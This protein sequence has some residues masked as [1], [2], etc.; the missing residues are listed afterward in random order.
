MN[1][2]E[3]YA[4][5][6]LDSSEYDSKLKEAGTGMEK[7]GGA[8]S[9]GL[10][11]AAA[12]GAAAVG[13]ASA[14]V[15]GLAKEALS[16]Y[17]EYEQ[18]VGGVEKLYG[19]ASGKIQQFADEAYK[20]SGMSANTY[21]E[22]ATSFSASLIK[23]L[24][25][26]VNKAAELTDVA[27]RAMS[28]NINVFGSDMGSVTNAFQGF[29][30]QNYTM[31]DNLKLGYGGTKEEM[32]KLI[33]DANEYAA[34]IGQASDLSIDSFADIVQAI[35]LI[36]EKQ[37]IAGTTGKEAMTTLEGSATATKAA[38]E[39]VVTA[40]GRG[41]GIEEALDGF[42][43]S[44][45]GEK[46]GEGLLNQI[47]PR[48]ETIFEGIGKFVEK[49]APYIEKYIPPLFS[50][51]LNAITPAVT[52]LL[53]S[54]IPVVIPLV[55]NL[56]DAILQAL[57]EKFP[58]LAA[59]FDNF[60]TIVI[61]AMAVLGGTQ[62]LGFISSFVSAISTIGGILGGAGIGGSIIGVISSLGALI[63]GTIIPALGALVAAVAPVL[64]AAAPF[65]AIGAAIV[66]AGVL[67]YQNWDTIKE[68]AG[69]LAEA[70]SEKWEGIKTAVSEKAQE[71]G[72]GVAEK[73][74]GMKQA[75]SD[76]MQGVKDFISDKWSEI[77]VSYAEGGDGISG[78]AEVYFDQVASIIRDVMTSIGDLIGV[79][80]S[81]I[82][83]AFEERWYAI[84]N[85]VVDIIYDL[86][87]NIS[88]KFNSISDTITGIWDSIKNAASSWGSDLIGNF[89][90]GLK[91]K[92]DA[93][94]ETV[95]DIAE[96]IKDYL[97]FSE[98]DKGPLSNFHTYA[99]D[100]MNLFAKGIKD[101]A[102][103][104][105]NAIDDSFDFEDS[106]KNQKYSIKT[107]TGG[108]SDLDKI[109]SLLQYIIDNGVHSDIELKGDASDIFSVVRR[110][111]YEFIQSTGYSGL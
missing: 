100:M 56:I 111:N 10:K 84:R 59:I 63:T 5:L 69:E 65:I 12:V 37:N 78:L 106:I 2:F 53:Q 88:D 40:I 45:F 24:G 25:G 73:W 4:K 66:A 98:P 27:M 104:V 61:G 18:L 34:S 13:T 54:I 11:T 33:D 109:V 95:S 87:T 22:T 96:S 71:I 79:D 48:L 67:I 39:N 80:L 76:K 7:L 35:E 28:D 70:V 64:V 72:E 103:L 44:V 36:Q 47:I 60:Q 9:T 89:I 81:G 105:T 97:G 86:Q 6:G 90:E 92:W 85:T 102:K 107:G 1:V 49:A 32:Q 8:I 58:Q 14:A 75:V 93:L 83:D 38:W 57:S 94:K 21:M 31:L 16:S 26:D 30:K 77:Q 62:I 68:K 42:I 99:P 101:N 74:E 17:G 3:L 51:L 15:V 29:A 55:N 46:E 108:T 52:S 20:T 19:D 110:K 43:N 41:E 91:D 50:Q 82:Y 23:S